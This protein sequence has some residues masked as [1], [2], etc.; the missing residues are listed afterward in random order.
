MTAGFKIKIIGAGPTGALLALSLARIGCNI[1]LEDIN[2]YNRIVNKSR[3]YALSH[4]SIKILAELDLWNSL[5]FNAQEFNNLTLMDDVINQQILFDINDLPNKYNNVTSIGWILDHNILMKTIYKKINNT[6]N[7]D[8]KLESISSYLLDKHDFVIAADGCESFAKRKFSIKSIKYKYKQ[9]CVTAKV[10]FR[11][12]SQSRAY[13]IM[14]KD[15]PFAIL[16]MGGDVF[17][18]VWSCLTKDSN[19]LMTMQSSSFLDEMATFMPNGIEPDTILDN[20]LCFPV[21]FSVASKF[22]KGRFLLVGES[23]HNFHP[24]GGQGL[25][26]CWRDVFTLTKIIKYFQKHKIIKTALPSIYFLLR[27]VDV[28]SIG[29]ITDLLIRIYSNNNKLLIIFRYI[30]VKSVNYLKGIRKI[31]LYLMTNGIN[32]I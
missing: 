22:F 11:G 3:A 14:R 16:P 23:A 8:L 25:N 17:Q 9:S 18:I 10:L 21:S 1:T 13:E 12:A 26:L 19:R 30:I 7:I 5:K 28:Y 29:I 20:R 31:I 4:S 27:I 6:K 2:A 24:V 32:L 15:G